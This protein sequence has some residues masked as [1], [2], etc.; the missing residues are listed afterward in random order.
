MS[1]VKDEV[2]F[3]PV[4]NKVEKEPLKEVI[5]PAAKKEISVKKEVV[6]IKKEPEISIQNQNQQYVQGN[7][8]YSEDELLN[9]LMQSNKEIK[10]EVQD[11]WSLISNYQSKPAYKYACGILMDANVCAASSK[12]ILLTYD[13]KSQANILNSKNAQ[14]KVREFIKELFNEEMVVYGLSNDEF[15]KLT[16]QFIELRRSG[17]LPEI[18]PI[19]IKEIET[20]DI[21][22][23]EKNEEKNELEEFGNNLFGSLL[24]VEE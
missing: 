9:M 10:S 7:I 20:S 17:M 6:E 11:R 18:K 22:K 21:S 24:E 3:I 14:I 5:K 15:K 8:E 4:T 16:N 12:S 23:K 1:N 19:V 13:I 2:E